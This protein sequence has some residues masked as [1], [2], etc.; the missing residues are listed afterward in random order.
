MINSA[1]QFNEFDDEQCRKMIN[2]NGNI[3]KTNEVTKKKNGHMSH[4]TDSVDKTDLTEEVESEIELVVSAMGSDKAKRGR[5]EHY[6]E[7]P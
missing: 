6:K 2:I 4:A 5:G 3:S 1:Q 7:D